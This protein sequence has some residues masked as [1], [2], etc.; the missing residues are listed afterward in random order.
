MLAVHVGNV[1]SGLGDAALRQAFSAYGVITKVHIRVTVKPYVQ[2]HI[3][4]YHLTGAL[5]IAAQFPST[6][7]H[8]ALALG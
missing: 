7:C 1:D 8:V 5:L 6:L 2:I 3:G 4:S